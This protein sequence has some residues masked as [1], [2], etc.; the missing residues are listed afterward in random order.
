[1]H[2]TP[3]TYVTSSELYIMIYNV[4]H[5][6]SLLKTYMW[7]LKNFQ[8]KILTTKKAYSLFNAQRVKT[9]KQK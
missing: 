5:K 3:M 6:L 9:N 2:F 1:M 7:V 8:H 4:I